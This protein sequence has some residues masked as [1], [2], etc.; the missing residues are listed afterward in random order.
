MSQNDIIFLNNLAFNLLNHIAISGQSCARV[1]VQRRRKC[2]ETTS[3]D[4][5][6]IKAAFSRSHWNDAS[7]R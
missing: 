4:I 5:V 6:E 3:G 2:M 7:H 1:K